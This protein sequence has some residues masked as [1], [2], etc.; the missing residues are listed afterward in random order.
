MSYSLLLSAAR[1]RWWMQRVASSVSRG[2]AWLI[3]FISL[4][5]MIRSYV[6]HD[7]WLMTHLCVCLEVPRLANSC[8]FSLVHD[9]FMREI[10]DMTNDSWLMHTCVWRRHGWRIHVISLWY[11]VTPSGGEGVGVWEKKRE[12]GD[13]CMSTRSADAPDGWTRK[14]TFS[15]TMCIQ[16]GCVILHTLRHLVCHASR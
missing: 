13:V 5:Y 9:S 1:R 14:N 12:W 10:W 15:S 2:Y 16:M 6:W 8:L 3:H 11:T 4:L 7:S